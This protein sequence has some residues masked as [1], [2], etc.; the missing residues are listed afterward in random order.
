MAPTTGQAVDEGDVDVREGGIG[1]KRHKG[2]AA[3]PRDPDVFIMVGQIGD[4]GH[5]F[6]ACA[7]LRIR[8]CGRYQR[9]VGFGHPANFS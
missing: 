5:D 7:M 2:D 9:V 6:A 8:D 4:D 1:C 3:C